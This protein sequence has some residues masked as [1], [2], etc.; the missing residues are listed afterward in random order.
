MTVVT[1]VVLVSIIVVNYAVAFLAASVVV[2]KAAVAEACAFIAVYVIVPDDFLTAVTDCCVSVNTVLADWFAIDC[3]IVIALNYFSAVGTI[4]F[5][6]HL[7]FLRKI[8]ISLPKL[9]GRDFD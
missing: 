7:F 2:F 4:D 1:V 3:V 6:F 9:I 5:F 8:K